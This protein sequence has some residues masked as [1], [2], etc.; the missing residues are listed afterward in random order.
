MRTKPKITIFFYFV[1]IY[2]QQMW[3]YSQTLF[4]VYEQFCNTLFLTFVR[5]Q[6]NILHGKKKYNVK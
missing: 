3:S 1:L 4:L 6:K 2:H 5:I